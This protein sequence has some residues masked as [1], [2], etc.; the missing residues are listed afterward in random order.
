VHGGDAGA[1]IHPAVRAKIVDTAV[2]I[3]IGMSAGSRIGK[4][5]AR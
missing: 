5:H 4:R 2:A 3:E 1:K